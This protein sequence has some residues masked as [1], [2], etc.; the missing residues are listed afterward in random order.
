MVVQSVINCSNRLSIPITYF[1]LYFYIIII[2]SFVLFVN[3]F[4]NFFFEI[5]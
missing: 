1:L 2:R 5:C 3:T 4:F